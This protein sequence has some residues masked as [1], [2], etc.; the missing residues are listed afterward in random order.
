MT[1]AIREILPPDSDHS[2]DFNR[3][4]AISE[5][6]SDLMILLLHSFMSM[7]VDAYAEIR[8][9]RMD[10]LVAGLEEPER[11]INQVDEE[12]PEHNLRLA[13]DIVHIREPR[14]EFYLYA[15]LRDPA[16]PIDLD[17]PL[18]IR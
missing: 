15:T 5:T 12:E 10:E 9:G 14:L 8:E 6:A 17:F 18:V 1:D 4:A 16:A 7:S 13:I 3:D 2:R 11:F